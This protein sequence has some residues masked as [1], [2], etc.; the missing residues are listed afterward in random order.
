MN[1]DDL[2]FFLAVAR[3]GS[4]SAA[5]RVLGVTQ[6]TIGR[7]MAAFERELGAQLFVATR[8]GQE[9]SSTGRELKVHAER[10]ELDALAAE[11]ASVGRDLG[12]R[13]KVSIT[14]SEWLVGGLLAP[15]LAPLAARHPELELE[16]IA[17]PRHLSLMRREVDVAL[18]PSRF[19]DDDVVQRKLGIIAFGLYASEAYLERH[20]Q[21]NFAD[22]C[23]GHRLIAMSTGLTKIP[24]LEWL[25]PLTHQAFVAMRCNGREAMATLASAGVG[26]ACLPRL[27]GDRSPN[28]Q[29]LRAPSP[30]P[31][32]PLWLGVHRDARSLPRIRTTMGFLTEV[33]ERHRPLLA[34]DD[35]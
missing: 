5:A 15:E 22:Y 24:D 25:P 9:L 34:P 10:M 30:A 4:H 6:P 19:E 17:E 14:A 28:L 3:H 35:S 32:R 33:I 29:L 21:P 31:T 8:L 12:V 27:L 16:L 2:R 20:G 13:G 26:I 7:R 23:H 18:R 11:R 1:W